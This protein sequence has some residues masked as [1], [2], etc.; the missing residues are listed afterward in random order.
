MGLVT[1]PVSSVFGRTGDVVLG[2]GDI[3]AALGYTPQNAAL[4]NTQNIAIGPT[5]SARNVIQPTGAAVVPLTIQGFAGQSDDL[6]LTKNS[7]GTRILSVDALGNPVVPNGN[8]VKGAFGGGTTGM[9]IVSGNNTHLSAVAN[10]QIRTFY[11]SVLAIDCDTA[12][13]ATFGG[14]I[15]AGASITGFYQAIGYQVQATNAMFSPSYYGKAQYTRGILIDANPQSFL[16]TTP[17]AGIPLVVLRSPASFTAKHLDL[18]LSDQTSYFSVAWNGVSSSNGAYLKL[19]SQQ[20]AIQSYGGITYYDT[21]AYGQSTHRFRVRSSND[22]VFTMG[23]GGGNI[24]YAIAASSPGFTV[25]AAPSSTYANDLI[26]IKNAVGTIVS[27]FDSVG[28]LAIGVG[29]VPA[30]STLIRLLGSAGTGWAIDNVDSTGFNSHFIVSTGTTPAS[31]DYYQSYKDASGWV[32]AYAGGGGGSAQP[33]RWQMSGVDALKIDTSGNVMIGAT[34][35]SAKLLVKAN[36]TTTQALGIQIGPGLPGSTHVASLYDSVG[37]EIGF[38]TNFGLLS[39]PNFNAT[40]AVNSPLYTFSNQEIIGFDIWKM[41]IGRGAVWTEVDLW[42]DGVKR[43]AL[44]GGNFGFNTVDYGS[45]AGVLAI[46]NVTTAPTVTPVGGG[47][48]YTEAGALK[49]KGSSGT[50]TT[51]AAA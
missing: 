7:V 29:E 3:L 20:D 50:V 37:A 22:V 18:Q 42:T 47:V 15:I 44:K 24:A 49:Y 34:T 36:G 6:F 4:P 17:D 8:S 28:H 1:F 45:G 14:N 31:G 46:A 9:L 26:T 19:S 25:L 2:S 21:A 5:T 13:N 23:D 40:S 35:T 39:Y 38:V 41:H 48:L 12:G 16:F 10:V 27:R 51:I 30:S 33:V 32:W 11:D 43:L